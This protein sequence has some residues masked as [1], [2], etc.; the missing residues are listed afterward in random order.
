MTASD[1]G[2]LPRARR[3]SHP[4]AAACDAETQ[5]DRLILDRQDRRAW[6]FRAGRN[7]AHRRPPLPLRDRFLADPI[8]GCQRPQARLTMLYRS[9]D[10]LCR[11]GAPMKN[12]AHSAS[13]HSS[14]KSALSKPGI[15]HLD[16]S[17]A[18][19]PGTLCRRGRDGSSGR[20]LWTHFVRLACCGCRSIGLCPRW[21]VAGRRPGAP[22]RRLP[23]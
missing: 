1:A 9:T 21:T 7:V 14:V 13:F 5:H 16:T 6:L 11:C 20:S 15:K 10:R 23:P 12:L 8:S 3:G 18:P 22:G 19:I 2:L 17:R 4:A